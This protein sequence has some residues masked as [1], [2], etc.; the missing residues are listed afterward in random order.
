MGARAILRCCRG[1]PAA[2]LPLALASCAGLATLS[3]APDDALILPEAELETSLAPR[4][5]GRWEGEVDMTLPERIL[6]IPSVRREGGR[7][8]VEA[9]YGVTGVN[10]NP[11]PVTLDT[12][13]GRVRLRF[14]SQLGSPVTLTL[15]RDDHLRGAL[16][17]AS[18]S[19]DRAMTLKRVST[20]AT[21]TPGSTALER[22]G[23]PAAR[24]GT[25]GAPALT[26]AAESPSE[27]PPAP[28]VA[29]GSLRDLA[30]DLPRLLVGRWD[31]KVELAVAERSLLID[32]VRR[33]E[34]KWQIQ[35]R[36]GF[37]DKDAGPVPATLD[38]AGDRVIIRFVTQ[39]AS[40]IVLTLHA[41]QTL[42]GSFS[43]PFDARDRR[44]ELSKAVPP[45]RVEPLTIAFRYM[46]DQSRVAD[47]RSVVAA[48]VTS[49]KGV[50]R[51]S[52]AL[53][54][55]TVH[56]R[57]EPAPPRSTVLSVPVTFR[58]G[59]NVI[60][61]TASEPDGTVRHEARTIVYDPRAP[62]PAPPLPA[63][64]GPRQRWAVVIGVGQHDHAGIP[65]LRYATADADAVYRT[66]IERVGFKPEH[67]LLLTDQTERKPSLRNIRYA[68]GTFLAR[69]AA[70]DDTVLIY[71]AGHG[72]PET[73]L[74]GAE[75][76]GL[77][78][79]LIP[80]D[81]DPDDLY[82]TA[83]PMD[84]IQTIFGRI[85]AERV[86]VFLDTC[87]SGAAGG[88][89]FASR[90][91]RAV[92]VDD[93]FL[94]RLTRSKGR[95]I[96]TASRPGEVSL[97]LPDLGHGIF[98]YYLVEGLRGAA[99]LNRDGTVSLQELYEYVE[100]EV[101]RK[102]RAVGGNQHPVMKGE[103]EGVLP[104]AEVRP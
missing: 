65:R 19:H 23:H 63:P 35:A 8:L 82:A 73:D 104:L 68:L 86:L 21:L 102:S 39:L 67:V 90:R 24:G 77:A 2:L 29:P 9:Q 41:D 22:L 101:T 46:A 38:V 87:Y 98:T 95:A 79:Y 17:V 25:A 10:L 60:A 18:E 66:L 57:V 69:S 13:G 83:L 55:A 40:R 1:V 37:T 62:T 70:R 36:Y 97:E 28:V 30:L 88:R 5:V 3:P 53:N 15:G 72:A 100:R 31:G 34:G 58:D 84:E 49:S 94:E 42:R 74:R 51:V 93:A 14:V 52:V 81:A 54:G 47:P 11:V 59:P 33:H 6:L 27:L 85:E 78:K 45:E 103:M 26:A 99:D 4:L 92:T 75:R 20:S 64:A 80:R 16:R 43:M 61:I 50:A 96:V 48:I 32:S 71:F 89:T 44:L 7:W 76:D 12:S 56:E 91:T